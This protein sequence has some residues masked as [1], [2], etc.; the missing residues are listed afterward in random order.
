M[1]HGMIEERL[2]SSPVLPENRRVLSMIPPHASWG[3]LIA[4]KLLRSGGTFCFAP[5]PDQCLNVCD[6]LG[7][8]Y[9]CA[10][11][12]QAATLVEEQRKAPRDLARLNNILV[13]GS[14][15]APGLIDNLRRYIC[16]NVIITYG[17]S[18][19]GQVASAPQSLIAQTP[20][21]VGYLHP[22]SRVE[23][24]DEQD[25]PSSC[26]QKRH[27]PNKGRRSRNELPE[28][29]HRSRWRVSRRL[30]LPW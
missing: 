29:Q 28:R 20:G 7:V 25:R 11:V 24:V 14:L 21:A 13:G 6:S 26:R 12:A 1:T 19:G 10:S 22:G 17:A 2:R 18:E 16:R 4:L 27:R 8:E 5:F 23:I 30:V 9:I 3:F 15:V